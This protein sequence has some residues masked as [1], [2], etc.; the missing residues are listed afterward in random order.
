M[1]FFILLKKFYFICLISIS[2]SYELPKSCKLTDIKMMLSLNQND[3]SFV[4]NRAV[5]CDVNGLFHFEFDQMS[6]F[7]KEKRNCTIHND[8][9]LCN[10]YYLDLT[11]P[12]NEFVILDKKFN[13]SQMLEFLTYFEYSFNINFN[14][15]NG[16]DVNL[17]EDNEQ[18]NKMIIQNE[19]VYKAD[20]YNFQFD[21]Y[22]DNKLV[23]SCED[24]L[25]TRKPVRSIFQIE[26]ILK[27]VTIFL[28]NIKIHYVLWYLT[29]LYWKQSI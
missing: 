12:K 29:I 6:S 26:R 25:I 28:E 21:F 10:V 16:V 9:Y 1:T 18:S 19:R 13:I 8:N 22:I 4:T 14:N 17:M 27:I 7:F 2:F 20:L 15:F 23:K 3:I 24:I 5:K 11:S